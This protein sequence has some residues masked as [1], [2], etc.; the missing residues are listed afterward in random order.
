MDVIWQPAGLSGLGSPRITW[1]E[2]MEMDN[3]MFTWVRN[4]VIELR[5]EEI[6]RLPKK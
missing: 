5:N 3:Q 4:K 1:D 6:K 2:V